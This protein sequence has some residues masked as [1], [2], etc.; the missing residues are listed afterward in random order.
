MT[1]LV[2]KSNAEA[3]GKNGRFG[4]FSS[5]GRFVSLVIKF[6]LGRFGRRTLVFVV[7]AAVM[8]LAAATL[9]PFRQYRNQGTSIEQAKQQLLELEQ[10]RSD[11]ESRIDRAADKEIIEREARKQM[12]L[13]RPGDELFRVVV[14][15]D[16][17]DLPQAWYLPGVEYLITGQSK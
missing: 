9:L 16:V 11:L 14:P 6:R 5:S 4:R 1:E 12:S 7:V 17:I 8:A 3:S 15:S 13:V 10:R 2:K